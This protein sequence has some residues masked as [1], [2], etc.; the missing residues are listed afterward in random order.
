MGETNEE[1]RGDTWV[2]EKGPSESGS[3]GPCKRN[4]QG[5]GRRREEV[6]TTGISTL[7][8]GLVKSLSSIIPS[9]GQRGMQE[10][11]S[12]EGDRDHYENSIPNSSHPVD[13][14]TPVPIPPDSFF[15]PED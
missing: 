1:G 15:V 12:A 11:G 14:D 10:T 9:G 6:M 5:G 8:G 13:E 3:K 7:P 4:T 2:R